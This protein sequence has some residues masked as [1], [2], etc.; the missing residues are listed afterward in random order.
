[1]LAKGISALV[2][3]LVANTFRRS[4]RPLHCTATQCSKTVVESPAGVDAVATKEEDVEVV[5]PPEE[6]LADS[7]EAAAQR[8]ILPYNHGTLQSL[9]YL[10]RRAGNI[11][12]LGLLASIRTP[13]MWSESGGSTANG[14]PFGPTGS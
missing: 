2:H 10:I 5:G 1:M 3:D 9:R 7:E 11:M 6:V 8:Q 12:Y 14:T 13:T 4:V